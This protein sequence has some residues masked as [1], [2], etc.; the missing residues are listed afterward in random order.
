MLPG[1]EHLALVETT[2]LQT[3]IKVWHAL[4]PLLSPRETVRLRGPQGY[5]KRAAGSKSIPV[6]QH[7]GNRAA[8]MHL[9]RMGGQQRYHGKLLAFDFDAKVYRRSVTEA[10]ARAAI[11]LLGD[12]DGTVRARLI[13]DYCEVSGG[14]H[15]ILPLSTYLPAEEIQQMFAAI[16]A[17]LKGPGFAGTLDTSPMGNLEE[18]LLRPPG[19]PHHRGGF[20]QLLTP[21]PEAIITARRGNGPA[22]WERLQREFAVELAALEPAAEPEPEQCEAIYQAAGWRDAAG[23]KVLSAAMEQIAR[24][25]RWDRTRYAS[26]SH[27]RFALLVHLVATGWTLADV[28]AGIKKGGGL[29]GLNWLL[30]HSEGGSDRSDERAASFV[31]GEWRRAAAWVAKSAKK[32]GQED[33]GEK[34]GQPATQVRPVNTGGGYQGHPALILHGSQAGSLVHDLRGPRL[35]HY[36]REVE[37]AL[38]LLHATRYRDPQLRML[39]QGLLAMAALTGQATLAVGIRALSLASGPHRATV[40][41]L[42]KVLYAEDD[43]LVELVQQGAGT[44]ADLIRLRIPD[45]IGQLVRWRRWRP[46][47][48]LPVHPVLQ[49]LGPAATAAYHALTSELTPRWELEHRSALP[50]RTLRRA[51]DELCAHG[52]AERSKTYWRRVATPD[53]LKINCDAAMIKFRDRVATYQAERLEWHRYLGEVP[54]VLTSEFVMDAFAR[55][56]PPADPTA[57]EPPG[58]RPAPGPTAPAA[59]HPTALPPP[60]TEA[61]LAEERRAADPPQPPPW[62]GADDHGTPPEPPAT[63]EAWP[64][65]P[66]ADFDARLDALLARAA[67]TP[68]AEA[69]PSPA[70]IPL[71]ASGRRLPAN[72]LAWS[73]AAARLGISEDAAR[74]LR[75]TGRRFTDREVA[76]LRETKTLWVDDDAEARAEAE[77]RRERAERRAARNAARR[78][79]WAAALG[80]PERMLPATMPAYSLLA[81]AE[82]LAAD[83]AWL[84]PDRR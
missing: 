80:V 38:H 19:A 56:T 17:R 72:P 1:L 27:A 35:Y 21:L 18:G 73:T 25:A 59:T 20:Q 45:T 54:A 41:E 76:R 8:A 2:P 58:P 9:Y 39:L 22:V 83:P 82:L 4:V 66:D 69:L 50:E 32:P 23:N 68:P 71:T 65:Q 67:T 7:P 53:Q 29:P 75:P 26:I 77:R 11:K 42:L 37:T 78:A 14:W 16:A 44:D 5:T 6:E 12:Q 43:P 46:G 70:W 3:S 24:F 40:A 60:D 84:K 52:L 62:W 36:L 57:T 63:A 15:V 31:K 33:D 81:E 10:D 51:L 74:G 47:P 55:S 34:I 48:F 79:E 49:Q 13:V 64:E 30:T 61:D 28:L